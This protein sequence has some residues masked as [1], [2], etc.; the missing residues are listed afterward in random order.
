MP[1]VVHR[2]TLHINFLHPQGEQEPIT[3]V[4][5]SFLLSTGR[6][7]I[8]FVEIIVLGAFV[9]RFKLD[10][11]LQNN[12][13]AIA[14][15][16]PVIQSLKVDEQLIRQTQLQLATIK[17]IKQNDFDY[18]ALLQ[19]IAG[20]TPQAV[21]LTNISLEKADGKMNLKITGQALNNNDLTSFVNGIKSDNSLANVNLENASL[22]QGLII[23][24]L[25][26]TA[27]ISGVKEL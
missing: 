10:S 1:K 19:K 5:T 9:S 26:G 3:V 22:E 16:V 12:N 21:K 27:N 15:Q 23:F 11:D 20:S 18:L 7:I 25:T 6:F 8:I 17:D 24:S 2:P 13:E 14:K 4:L